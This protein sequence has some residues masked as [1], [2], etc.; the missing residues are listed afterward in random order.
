[1][2]RKLNSEPA[3]AGP[4]K[5]RP[6]R[7]Q[8]YGQAEQAALLTI[9]E[10]LDFPGELKLVG[11][12]PSALASL[13]RYGDLVLEPGVRERL[14]E[15]SP[16]TAGYLFRQTDWR[17]RA[18]IRPRRPPTRLQAETP[19]RT[20]DSWDGARPGDLQADTVF[21]SGPAA[22]GSH[23]YT[24]LASD[25]CTGWIEA[26]VLLR[27]RQDLVADALE[28]IRVRLPFRW[29]SLHS[30]NGSELLN[31]C[32]A[33]WCAKHGIA[34]TRGRPGKPNDQAYV[35]QCNRTFVRR[36]VGD[37]RLSGPAA[38]K[39]LAALYAPAADFANSFD[40]KTSKRHGGRAKT[41]HERL[42]ESG[43]LGPDEQR[44]LDER[45]AN[46]R[47]AMLREEIDRRVDGLAR[48]ATHNPPRPR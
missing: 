7:S 9:R 13:E 11:S 15:M 14:L 41:P 23:L 42:T 27:L 18:A 33:A 44:D 29:R 48:H 2:I 45:F 26:E 40:A 31:G 19:L 28:R 6:G 38:R 36:L 24:L 34:R 3:P 8:K 32:V 20:W 46:L 10:Y 21:H 22:G 5:S 25:P 1:M 39:A 16:A 30:D 17:S 35:E 47:L 12:L 4:R 43:V 37:V